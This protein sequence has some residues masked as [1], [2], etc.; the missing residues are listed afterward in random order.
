M[1]LEIKFRP[2]DPLDYAEVL[3]LWL[4][5][6]GV[7]VA[8]GDD[9]ES[10]VRYLSRNPGLSYAAVQGGAIVGAALCGHDGRRGLVYHLAVAPECRGRGVGKQILM[11]GLAG[12]RGC[13]IARVVIFVEKD[14]SRG[15]EFWTSRGFEH[16]SGALPL[17]LDLK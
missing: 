4:R 17:G 6:D 8:E 13:G 5:C 16:I 15:Q 11:M 7:E 3:A 10:Y 2:L 9:Q 14:N 1:Q 12:L